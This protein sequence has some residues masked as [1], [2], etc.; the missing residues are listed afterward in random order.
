M[1]ILAITDIHKD[2]E[3]ARV[4]GNTELPDLVLDC[5]DHDQV[6]NLF[7]KCPHFYIRG[8]HEPDIITC[9]KENLPLPNYI[10]NGTVL[11]FSDG[12]NVITFAGIDG[13]YG[14][15][16]GTPHVNPYVLP[17]LKQID[18]QLIDVVLLHESPFNVA[19]TSRSYDVAQQVIAE[20]ERLQPKLVLSGH[21]NKFS[22][23]VTE[24][25][26]KFINLPDMSCGYLIITV[27]G[28]NLTYERKIARYGTNY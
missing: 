1:K 10:P 27:E 4:A 13:N 18:P 15:R 11:E 28:G 20:I 5:G 21:T 16:Q 6:I 12:E 26:V 3:A 17:F 8:N 2:Y 25:N 23:H 24:K 7:G 22:E 9:A 14:S 19:K